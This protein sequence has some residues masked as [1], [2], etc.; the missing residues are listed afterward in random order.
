MDDAAQR[1][2]REAAARTAQSAAEG[3]S[4]PTAAAGR[5]VTRIGSGGDEAPPA[6]DCG[7]SAAAPAA[8]AA[9]VPVPDSGESELARRAGAAGTE[10]PAAAAAARARLFDP[11]HRALSV[12]AVALVALVAFEALAVTTAMPTVARALDGLAWYA[13]AFGGTLAASVVGMVAAGRWADAR[14]P[15]APLRQGIAWFALGLALAGL[16]PGMGWL[17]AGRVVQGFGGGLISVALYVVVG[18]AY[19]EALRVKVFAA[20]A[21]AWVVPAV[22]GPAVSGAIVEHLGWRWVF[23]SVPAVAVLAAALVLPALRG[24]GP[25]PAAAAPG[26]AAPAQAARLGWAMLATASLLALHYGGQQRGWPALALLLP[27]IA[28]L[29]LAASRLLPAG[30]LRAARGLPT[31]VALRGI[32]AG[33][34]FMSEAFIPLLLSR[35]RG[36]SPT[37]AG[38]VLTLGALGWSGGS[39]LRGRSAQAR[40]PQRYLQAGLALVALGVLAIAALVAPAAPLALGIGGWVLAGFG[41]GLVYP[42]LSVLTLELSAPGQQGLNSSAL[43]LGDAIYTATALAVGGSVFAALF[44]RSPEWAF[45]CGFAIAFVLAAA[46]S[47]LAGRVVPNAA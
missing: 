12:G 31:V 38:L 14:G 4:A 13:L 27:A 24:L 32:A 22:V 16:A 28:A 35:E 39:W 21:A 33:A 37:W 18:R 5:P 41:M 29:A 26:E 9:G 45:G 2:A 3:A 11:G 8:A 42:T 46:G 40:Q 17:V 44:A 30:A 34:F 7:V 43:H 15:A 10:A 1:T 47:M 6:V 23:L 25:E 36:L 20:F 19:P